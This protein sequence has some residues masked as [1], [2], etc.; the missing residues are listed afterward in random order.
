M[1]RSHQLTPFS[2]L[3]PFDYKVKDEE[4][5]GL[6]LACYHESSTK[7]AKALFFFLPDHGYSAKNFGSLF[8]QFSKELGVR[9]YSFDRRGFGGSQGRRWEIKGD[10]RTF[11]DHWDFVETCTMLRG[12]PQAIPKILVSHG[13]GSLYAAHMCAQRPGFFKA[14]ISISP[15][16][17]M[18]QKPNMFSKAVLTAKTFTSQGYEAYWPQGKYLPK[19]FISHIPKK[20]RLYLDDTMTS[21]S[22][23]AIMEM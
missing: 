21:N 6:K 2:K 18:G 23:L 13:L 7:N 8:T 17:A 9:S 20:D 14:S 12:Y 11:Q 15:W 3:N 19:D 10:G 16:F 4:F 5:K 1:G 22:Y